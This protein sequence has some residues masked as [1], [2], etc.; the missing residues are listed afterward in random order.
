MIIFLLLFFSLSVGAQSQ[1]Y[2]DSL[3][4]YNSYKG[5]ID[6]IR[7][8]SSKLDYRSWYA[9]QDKQDNSLACAFIRLKR[10]NGS[11]YLPIR[12]YQVE[13]F[14]VAYYYPSPDSMYNVSFSVIYPPTKFIVRDNGRTIIPYWEQ[15][16]FTKDGHKIGMRLVNPINFKEIKR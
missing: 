1:G 7:L 9:I 12:D 16:F 11:D 6:S 10:L 13:G 15:Y 3:L 8:Y 4:I 5:Q 14:G 2:S